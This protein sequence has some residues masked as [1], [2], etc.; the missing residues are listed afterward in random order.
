MRKPD[1]PLSS[2]FRGRATDMEE[3]ELNAVE[4]RLTVIENQLAMLCDFVRAV[5]AS[6]QETKDAGGMTGV[7]ARSL[8][9]NFPV[10]PSSPSVSAGWKVS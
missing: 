7:M 9:P 8:L 5:T 10:P 2:V 3:S 1:L 4:E 6:I